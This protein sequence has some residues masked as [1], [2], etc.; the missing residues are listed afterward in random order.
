MHDCLIEALEHGPINYTDDNAFLKHLL[1]PLE[2]KTED[3]VSGIVCSF[4]LLPSV[5]K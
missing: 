3:I 1:V 2:R 4:A 5:C